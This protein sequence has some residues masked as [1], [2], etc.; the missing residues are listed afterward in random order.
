[1]AFVGITVHTLLPAG[2]WLLDVRDASK[3]QAVGKTHPNAIG[4]IHL[5]SLPR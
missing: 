1:M 4:D 2:R 5:R 3:P